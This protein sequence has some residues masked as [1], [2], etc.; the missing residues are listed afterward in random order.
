MHSFLIHQY[1]FKQ[2]SNARLR[3][4]TIYF[5]L[6][7]NAGSFPSTKNMDNTNVTV[8]NLKWPSRPTPHP[9]LQMQPYPKRGGWAKGFPSTRQGRDGEES[10]WAHGVWWLEDH[11]CGVSWLF[12][13][14]WAQLGWWEQ[15]PEWPHSHLCCRNRGPRQ[16]RGRR[17]ILVMDWEEGDAKQMVYN[18][19]FQQLCHNQWCVL[20]V[21]L[22]QC[23]FT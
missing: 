21:T 10:D 11:L 17:D 4:L 7:L 6:F 5:L 15:H 3:D 1:S 20:A 13:Q 18:T 22:K 16:A 2:N 19:S 12:Q 9:C 23:L 8:Y 14:S